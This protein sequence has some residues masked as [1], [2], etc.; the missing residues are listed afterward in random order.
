MQVLTNPNIN[1]GTVLLQKKSVSA[2]KVAAQAAPL[3]ESSEG[4]RDSV[5]LGQSD[6]T[7][8]TKF[9]STSHR[10]VPIG[11]LTTVGAVAGVAG[12]IA[13]AVLGGTAGVV[14]GALTLG[15]GGA[16][17]GYAGVSLGSSE[18]NKK[19]SDYLA[20]AAVWGVLGA[21][22]GAVAG[23]IGGVVPA[24]GAGVLGGVGGVAA[25]MTTGIG[26]ESLRAKG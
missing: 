14:T 18:P 15:I 1:S 25:G 10:E 20:G 8:S 4:S 2:D 3:S 5:S 24:I 11:L 22:A 21:V 16:A 17:F 26:I 12:G 9:V 23:L 13:S 6:S 7:L 19:A